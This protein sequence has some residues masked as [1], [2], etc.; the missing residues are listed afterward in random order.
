[1]ATVMRV[2]GKTRTGDLAGAIAHHMRGGGGEL[3]LQTIGAGACNQAAKALATARAF[4]APEGLAFTACPCWAEAANPAGGEGVVSAIW[5]HVL[6]VEEPRTSA[7]GQLPNELL[8]L[9]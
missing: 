9:D 4:L 2:R 7:L 6:P 5:F 1:M 8:G 3:V